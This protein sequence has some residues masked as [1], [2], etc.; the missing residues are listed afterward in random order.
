[1]DLYGQVHGYEGLYVIDAA[2][3][4]GSTGTVNPTLTIVA[5]AERAMDAILKHA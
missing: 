4:P 5:L 3:I 1:M 2:A